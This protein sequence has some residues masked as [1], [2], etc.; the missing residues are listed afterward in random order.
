MKKLSF[1]SVAIVSFILSSFSSSQTFQPCPVPTSQSYALLHSF[2]TNRQGPNDPRFSGIIAQSRGGNMFSTA[3]DTWTRGDGTVFKITRSAAVTTLHSFSGTDGAESV[4]G[5][6]LAT[7]GHYWGTTARGGL[8]GYGTIFKMTAGGALTTLHDFT[9]GADGGL[10][11]APPIEGI[12]EN[13]YGTTGIGGRRE[14][15][16]PCIGSLP[17]ENFRLS[18]RLAPPAWVIPMVLW[19]REVTASCMARPSTVEQ[20]ARAR[21]TKS[22]YLEISRLLQPLAGSSARILSGH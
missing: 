10:P 5:L 13:F 6:T 16:A 3:P 2:G 1:F 15:T 17:L 14:A 12:D 8:Y 18:T 20:M 11:G 9:G 19:F 7:G 21:F 4:S 22:A